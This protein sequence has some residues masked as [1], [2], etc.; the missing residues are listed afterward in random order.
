M[1]RLR[2]DIDLKFLSGRECIQVAIGIYQIQFGF[3][4]DV[5]IS[6]EGEF[7]CFDGGTEVVWRPKPG[8]AQ[9]ASRTVALPART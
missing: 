9:I 5:R 8:S 4:D 2:K 7:R 6:V 3:D 1:Y